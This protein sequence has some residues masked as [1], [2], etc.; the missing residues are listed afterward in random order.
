MEVDYITK[1]FQIDQVIIAVKR[2][3]KI[4]A[5]QV[6]QAQNEELQQEV[7]RGRDELKERVYQIDTLYELSKAINY[8][9]Y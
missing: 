4:Q 5:Y 7:R 6:Y 8:K 9:G 2:A 1:L 3:L